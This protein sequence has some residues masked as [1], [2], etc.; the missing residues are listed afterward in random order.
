MLLRGNLM[1]WP[2]EGAYLDEQA[3]LR[4]QHFWVGQLE[5]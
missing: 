5:A 3:T 4:D 2:E 1:P